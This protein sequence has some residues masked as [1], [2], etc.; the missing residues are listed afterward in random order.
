M[1]ADTIDVTWTSPTGSTLLLSH[2]GPYM[3]A[4]ITGWEESP[5]P[6][7][8]DVARANAHGSHDSPVW[9]GARNPV[10]EG[11]CY[12]PEDRNTLLAGLQ[13]GIHLG[14]ED[15]PGTITVTFAGRTL[16]AAGRVLRCGATLR[17]WGVGHF[18]WQVE[19]WC[20]DP[21][22]YGPTQT[23]STS[24]SI[25]VGGMAFPLFGA[26]SLLDFGGLSSPGRI[27]LDNPG[28]AD[29]W[30]AFV[31]TGPQPGGIE[32]V[33]LVTGRRIRWERSIPAG[34]TVALDARTGAVSYDGID[35]YDGY[36]TSR[37][38]WPIPP[39][40]S[41]TVQLNPLGTPD[42]TALLEATWS[43]AHW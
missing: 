10:V 3:V 16:S 34:V 5:S 32:L 2:E 17:N 27:T 8:D 12:S 37:Q 14:G 4:N 40:S 31:V 23:A 25:D 18:G 19:W 29:T 24:P 22:R 30:P 21:R 39:G 36:L 43:P 9:A 6:R 15:T 26:S 11:Y 38:W 13:S 41:R 42:P 20:P 1:A 28:S 7:V 33:E 35:G